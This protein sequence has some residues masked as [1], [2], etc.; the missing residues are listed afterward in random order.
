MEVDSIHGL[1][2]GSLRE[3]EPKRVIKRAAPGDKPFRIAVRSTPYSCDVC[4]GKSRG[5]RFQ[6][7]TIPFEFQ[8]W[9]PG[10]DPGSSNSFHCENRV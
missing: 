1:S 5:I 8:L 6:K 7:A 9:N 3:S 4:A 10:L 2:V